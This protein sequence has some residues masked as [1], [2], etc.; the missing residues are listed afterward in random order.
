MFFDL[1]LTD[2]QI[3]KFELATKKFT[4]RLKNSA[5]GE[6]LDIIP[7]ERD[8]QLKIILTSE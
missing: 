1:S 2:D 5:N 3:R 7:S 6:M 8:R 4:I